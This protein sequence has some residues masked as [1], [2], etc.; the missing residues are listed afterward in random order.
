M[1]SELWENFPAALAHALIELSWLEEYF[2]QEQG[3]GE[4][5]V[6][7]HSCQRGGGLEVRGHRRGLGRRRRGGLGPRGR[8]READGRPHVRRRGS[9]RPDERCTRA[10]TVA[11]A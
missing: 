9:G 10:S 5:T 2:E 6:G 11:R 4:W 3:W 1:S 7:A 8:R